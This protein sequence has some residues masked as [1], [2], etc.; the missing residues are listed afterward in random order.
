M[1]K[2]LIK[3]TQQFLQNNL[4]ATDYDNEEIQYRYEHSLRVANISLKLAKEE[5]ASEK[6]VVLGCLLHDVGKFN[7]NNN[8]EHGRVS[9]KI[10]KEFLQTQQLSEKEINDICYAIAVHVDGECGYEYEDTLESKI[11]SDSD[12]IDRYGA[13]RIYQHMSWDSKET[14]RIKEE[15]AIIE[16]RL[17]KLNKFINSNILETDSGNRWFKEHLELQKHY[18]DNYLKE[19]K[20]TKSPEL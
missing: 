18:F 1:M 16:K 19:L 3:K 5:G 6:I 13:Y 7:T 2:E 15:I 14:K 10:A 20:L 8:L 17:E 11:V 12:N 4:K 9:A